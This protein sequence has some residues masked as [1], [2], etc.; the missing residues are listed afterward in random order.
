MEFYTTF[1]QLKEAQA[2]RPRYKTLAKSLGGIK[3][4]GCNTPITMLQILEHNELDDTLW[5]LANCT[6][7]EQLCDYVCR[8]FAVG[9]AQNVLHIYEDKYPGEDRPRKSIIAA[10][11]FGY[12]E[13]SDE[14]LVVARDAAWDAAWAT[15]REAARDAARDAVLVAWDAA[16]AA[17]EAAWAAWAAARDA[18]WVAWDAAIE[19]ALDA[20]RDATWA[21]AWDA[22]L[23]YQTNLLRAILEDVARDDFELPTAL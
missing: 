12:G 20:A 1:T 17:R 2:C 19:V 4:Y 10:H 3:K 21:A 7:N 18:A 9:C 23:Q 8:I 16:W 6:N 22:E 5:T 11:L 13:I 15:A 14:E